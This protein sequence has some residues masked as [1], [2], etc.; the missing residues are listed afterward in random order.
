MRTDKLT[1]EKARETIKVRENSLAQ[2]KMLQNGKA[3][4]EKSEISPEE[5]RL[6][7]AVGLKRRVQIAS[8]RQRG[9]SQVIGSAASNRKQSR[10][11]R[12]NKQNCGRC[13]TIHARNNYPACD[14]IFQLFKEE[15]FS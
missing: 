13:G 15:S 8:D 12:C 2:M 11:Q 9:R 6:L 3:E 14:Q 7:D 5:A 1:I 4:E 10:T